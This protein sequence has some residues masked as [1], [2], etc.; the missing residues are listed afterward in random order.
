ME[1]RISMSN[2]EL[3]R[4][5]VITKVHEK[6]LTIAQAAEYL[7]LS[8]RQAYGFR[9]MAYFKLRLYHLHEQR[10]SFVG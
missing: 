4:L 9:D 2:A 3:S 1:G 5:E 7:N 10:Y 8:Q 6:R